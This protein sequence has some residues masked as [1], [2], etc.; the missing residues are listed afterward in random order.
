[1]WTLTPFSHLATAD[2]TITQAVGIYQQL[3]RGIRWMDWRP[4]M[5]AS[6]NDIYLGHFADK[7]ALGGYGQ[8]LAEAI[9]DVNNFNRDYPGELIVIDMYDGFD[10][11]TALTQHTF[12]GAAYQL[13]VNQ[14]TDKDTGLHGINTVYELT[15]SDG[16]AKVGGE[17]L[18]T[19]YALNRS[20]VIVRIGSNHIPEGTPPITVRGNQITGLMSSDQLPDGG[21]Y[22]DTDKYQVMQQDQQKKLSARTTDVIFK[23]TFTLTQTIPET[24]GGPSINYFAHTAMSVL[25][26]NLY[27]WSIPGVYPNLIEYDFVDDHQVAALAMALNVNLAYLNLP[28]CS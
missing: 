10:V 12:N 17:P 21:D 24:V 13:L 5:D 9:S 23:T 16:P 4:Y 22:A 6:R 28:V 1:M 8:S 2:N 27:R 20:P 11:V 3:L 14:L 26:D 25:N 7:F 15:N 18:S 19:F